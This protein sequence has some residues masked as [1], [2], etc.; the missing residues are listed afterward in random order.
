MFEGLSFVKAGK[1][2][3]NSMLVDGEYDDT[4]ERESI[5]QQ[6]FKLFNYNQNSDS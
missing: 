3:K 2:H 4:L 1:L 5:K 6:Y